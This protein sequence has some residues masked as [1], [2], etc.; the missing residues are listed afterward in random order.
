ML[1]HS[2][3]LQLTFVGLPLALVVTVALSAL[4]TAADDSKADRGWPMIGHDVANS[5]SQPDEHQIGRH[6]VG[7]LAPK[8]VLTTGGDVSATPAVS[9]RRDERDGR[10]RGR[11][12]VYF[13]DWG[14]QLWKVDAESGDVV[15]SRA[16]SEYN[17]IAGSISRSS[18]VLSHGNVY[19][20]DLNGSL[21]AIDAATGSLRWITLLDTHPAVIVTTSP[22]VLGNR[23][24]VATSS[25]E[26]AYARRQTP[27]PQGA[28]DLASLTV[29]NGVVY[30]GSMAHTGNQMYALDAATGSILWRFAAGGSVVAG[31][32]VSRG[33]VFWGSGYAR[34][35]GVGNDKFYAFRV[36]GR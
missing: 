3:C 26:Q 5:R 27:D 31:P 14:G 17:G 10:G 24:Y 4:P 7:R 30:A 8:W 6:Q 9:D 22:I 19:V 2:R 15:W 11:S 12:A 25:M 34:T 21:M 1:A 28:P 18:P 16:I 23:L 13:P 32:A 20:A 36:G 33:M 29:A 35:G